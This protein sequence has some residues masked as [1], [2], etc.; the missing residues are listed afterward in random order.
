M[1]V[2]KAW[3]EPMGNMQIPVDVW[4]VIL[5]AQTLTAKIASRMENSS[6]MGLDGKLSNSFPLFCLIDWCLDR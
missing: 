6:K 1:E 4:E 5:V 2:G 3:E